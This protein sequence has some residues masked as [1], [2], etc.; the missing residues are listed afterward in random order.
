MNVKKD[1]KHMIH[2]DRNYSEWFQDLLSNPFSCGAKGILFYIFA[3][4]SLIVCGILGLLIF[5][6]GRYPQ[7][8]LILP[9]L[10]LGFIVLY[11]YGYIMY[12]LPSVIA[13]PLSAI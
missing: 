2:D 11:I 5:P 7:I 13:V 12:K 3:F 8:I 9:G 1:K 6:S 10:I 4:P